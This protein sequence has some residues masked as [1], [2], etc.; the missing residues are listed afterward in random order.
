MIFQFVCF[1][2]HRKRLSATECLQH[3]W[4]VVSPPITPTIAVVRRELRREGSFK[5]PQASEGSDEDL[6]SAL[7]AK[8]H[9]TTPVRLLEVP[10]PRASDLWRSQSFTR[11]PVVAEEKKT[12]TEPSPRKEE[13]QEEEKVP[14]KVVMVQKKEE[15]EAKETF[16]EQVKLHKTQMSWIGER[17][18]WKLQA[19]EIDCDEAPTLTST[20]THQKSTLEVQLNLRP[21]YKATSS[22]S[23]VASGTL[24]RQRELYKSTGNLS[25]AA[26]CYTFRRV[27]IDGT[28]GDADDASVD[29]GME[30]STSDSGLD[31]T[32]GAAAV[33]TVVS[34]T[35]TTIS[36]TTTT[37]NVWGQERTAIDFRCRELGRR[38]AF[39]VP[40]PR[41]ERY[42]WQ[43]SATPASQDRVVVLETRP[44]RH[45]IT[46]QITIE[47]IQARIR[48][49]KAQALG[50]T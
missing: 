47:S 16:K 48:R 4:F 22:E 7:L 41:D 27:V 15:P 25:N 17:P 38:Q 49:L 28:S 8:A 9:R 46:S 31:A 45:P 35:S 19:M 43:V 40:T 34:S 14:V 12:K 1:F 10:E 20:P 26:D 42:R 50:R 5:K 30:S 44:G 29:S 21:L 23:L 37:R 3:P 32:A 33:P 6:R 13:K 18:V 39:I 11:K 2:A 24:I 36:S